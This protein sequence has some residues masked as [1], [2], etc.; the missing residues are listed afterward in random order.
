MEVHKFICDYD[1]CMRRAFAVL[2]Q[3]SDD[4]KHLNGWT[5]IGPKSA[6]HVSQLR[7][8]CRNHP[9]NKQS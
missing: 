1:G 7:H 2:E 4:F 3:N 6:E 9:D 5:G 8:Y